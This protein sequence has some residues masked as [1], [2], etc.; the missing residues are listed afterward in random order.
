[1]DSCVFR[2]TAFTMK[3]DHSAAVAENAFCDVPRVGKAR[4]KFRFKPAIVSEEYAERRTTVNRLVREVLAGE[5][6]HPHVS[7]E[8]LRLAT[9][10]DGPQLTLLFRS[11]RRLEAFRSD[12]T[13]AIRA[14]GCEK[15]VRIAMVGSAVRG[16]SCNPSKPVSPW[17]ASSDAD[18]QI[19]PREAVKSAFEGGVLQNPRI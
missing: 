17:S 10:R 1:M 8:R 4:A 12:C 2:S 16:W 14:A 11:W 6:D 3:I 7:A 13:D 9:R 18:F 15:S 19:I 5:R